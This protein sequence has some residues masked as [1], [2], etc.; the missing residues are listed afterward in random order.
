M[1]QPYIDMIREHLPDAT[2]VFDRFH[3][4]NSCTDFCEEPIIEVSHMR[5]LYAA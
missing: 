4:I 1:W 3:I 5:F 2:L